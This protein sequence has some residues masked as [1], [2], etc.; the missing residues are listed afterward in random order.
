VTVFVALLCLPPARAAVGEEVR[1]AASTG[2]LLELEAFHVGY[3]DGPSDSNV[4]GVEMGIGVQAPRWSFRAVVPAIQ[5]S[6]TADL[7]GLGPGAGMVAG[8]RRGADSGNGAGTTAA[9]AVS[10]TDGFV[11]SLDSTRR[12]LGDVRLSG[13]FRLGKETALGSWWGRV[14]LKAPT[15]DAAEGLGTGEWD[16]WA[17]VSWFREGWTVD[18]DAYVRWVRLGDPAD[19]ELRDGLAGGAFCEWPVGRFAMGAGLEAAQDAIAGEPARTAVS[20]YLRG[21]AGFRSS[22][23]VEILAGLSGNAPRLG[24]TAGWWY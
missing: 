18:F 12:G 10:D 19:L 13:A 7:V 23:S 20:S 16:E 1:P 14:G 24:V 22:W 2:L 11:S 8:Q 9:R 5:A 4:S 6:G 21:P 17:G 15:A 3:D